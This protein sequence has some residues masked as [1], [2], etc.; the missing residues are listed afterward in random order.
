M[1]DRYWIIIGFLFCIGVGYLVAFTLQFFYHDYHGTMIEWN[2]VLYGGFLLGCLLF[3]PL[4]L[5]IW[6]EHVSNSKKPNILEGV[7]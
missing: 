4:I 5:L 1:K 2:K 7:K 6:N 3:V